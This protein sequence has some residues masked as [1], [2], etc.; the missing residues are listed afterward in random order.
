MTKSYTYRVDT[1]VRVSSM[2]E[3]W[4][5]RRRCIHDL[6]SVR[7]EETVLA[8]KVGDPGAA[9]EGVGARRC[10]PS[11]ARRTAAC[12]PVVSPSCAVPR[13]VITRRATACAPV[14][15]PS[16]SRVVLQRIAA[17]RVAIALLHVHVGGRPWHPPS[18]DMP[19]RGRR[20]HA[21]APESGGV[22]ARG[23]WCEAAKRGSGGARAVACVSVQGWAGACGGQKGSGAHAHVWY[24][25]PADVKR[26]KQEETAKTYIVTRAHGDEDEPSHGAWAASTYFAARH[27]RQ[28]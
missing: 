27:A 25:G 16:S 8:V 20:E 15:W 24:V 13:R 11:R 22:A 14:A 21:R 9:N 2:M 17:R 5:G 18:C 19:R 7:M 12:A 28:A 3:R 6:P 1:G 10:C 4:C 26:R 23:T